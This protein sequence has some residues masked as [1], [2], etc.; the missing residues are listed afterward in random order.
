MD[1]EPE[2]IQLWERLRSRESAE[3]KTAFKEW[4][5][6]W[7]SKRQWMFREFLDD[8]DKWQFALVTMG[9]ASLL[10]FGLFWNLCVQWWQAKGSDEVN[11]VEQVIFAGF[12]AMLIL[13]V[14]IGRWLILESHRS[15]RTL[16]LLVTQFPD[17]RLIPELLTMNPREK[18]LWDF[19]GRRNIRLRRELLKVLLPHLQA[20]DAT[21]WSDQQWENAARYLSMPMVDVEFTLLMVQAAR[22]MRDSDVRERAYRLRDLPIGMGAKRYREILSLIKQAAL[23]CAP[24]RT[25]LRAS[26]AASVAPREE[27]LRPAVG[28]GTE[29]PPEQLLRP[30]TQT[31]VRRQ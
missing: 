1:E 10:T 20:G 9:V 14:A 25:L 30:S 26:D 12:L 16:R 31:E 3:F 2:G 5:E 13:I 6:L 23:D 21:K 19:A 8:Y 24:E 27:L 7:P 11:R 15:E 4:M 28:T 17:T 29:S 22:L 18:R